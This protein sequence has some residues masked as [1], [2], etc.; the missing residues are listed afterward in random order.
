MLSYQ[1]KQ[2]GGFIGLFG[3]LKQN[4]TNWMTYKQHKFIFRSSRGL[5]VQD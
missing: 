3:W 1:G 4:T 5:E 2:Y